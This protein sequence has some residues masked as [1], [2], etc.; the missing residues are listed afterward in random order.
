LRAPTRQLVP[1]NET[2]AW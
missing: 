1:I 2:D